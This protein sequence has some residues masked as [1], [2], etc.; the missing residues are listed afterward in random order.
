MICKSCAPFTH[1]IT[2]I[3]N[4]RVGNEKDLDVPML[5]CDLIEYNDNYSKRSGSSLSII[6]AKIAKP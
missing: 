4:T 2:E 1:C 3:N 5:M 6:D